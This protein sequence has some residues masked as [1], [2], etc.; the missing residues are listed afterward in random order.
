MDLTGKT[1]SSSV[2]KTVT[3]GSFSYPSPL[4]ITRTG[5]IEVK[6]DGAVGIVLPSLASVGRIVNRGRVFG[7]EGAYGNPAQTGGNG[8]D[9]NGAALLINSGVIAAGQGGFSNYNGGGG[10]IGVDVQAKSIILNSGKIA[11]GDGNSGY[12]TAGVGG[13]GVVIG[14]AATLLNSGTITGG[15]GGNSDSR[16]PDLYGLITGGVGVSTGSDAMIVNTGHITGGAGG[17][18]D[19]MIYYQIIGNAGAAGVA[20]GA[21]STLSNG[22][23]ITG[24]MGGRGY[25]GDGD[26]DLSVIGGNGGNGV[27]L[28]SATGANSGLINGGAGNYGFYQAGQGGSGVLVS[29]RG[30]LLNTGRVAGGAG[31]I[32][33]YLNGGAGGAGLEVS[34]QATAINKGNI[35]GG[36]GGTGSQYG[37]AGGVGFYLNH[38]TL[39]NAGTI[40]GGTGGYGELGDGQNG[41]AVTVAGYSTLIVKNGALF[42]GLVAASG[43]TGK[44]ADTLEVSGTSSAPLNDIGTEFTGFHNID[45]AANAAWTIA[46]DTAGLT[47][48]QEIKGFTSSDAI[49]LTDAAAS[50]GQA[51]V[52]TAGVVTITAGGDFYY[53]DIKGAT[54]G[55]SNFSFSNDTLRESGVSAAPAMTFLRPAQPVAASPSLFTAPGLEPLMSVPSWNQMLLSG[56]D[57]GA[58]SSQPKITT[59]LFSG[60]VHD[61]DRPQQAALQTMMTL[62]AG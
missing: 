61:M 2:Y 3:L 8:I 11:G 49:E 39:I 25:G 33:Y 22:G 37:G 41:D 35:S 52:G 29:D 14:V 32:S 5:K 62:H 24:G 53:L 19:Q 6:A 46:G 47:S 54:V 59:A 16:S 23:T 26:G 13:G 9:L 51:S 40:T 21:G 36:A 31:G 57:S 50:N 42:N 17:Y 7:A 27:Q 34:T 12:D 58:L 30:V 10:G 15:H 38:G 43:G 45:F 1:I 18:A 44:G 55:E 20:L 48:G 28:V 56:T 60:S 4:T